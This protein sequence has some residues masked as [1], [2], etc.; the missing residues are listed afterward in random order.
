MLILTLASQIDAFHS[1]AGIG[2]KLGQAFNSIAMAISGLV[3]A[4]IYG[5]S[6]TLVLLSLIP[7]IFLAGVAFG[8]FFAKA[9]HASD[10]GLTGA[11]RSS[12]LGPC[13]LPLLTGIGSGTTCPIWVA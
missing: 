13:M 10:A 8:M 7:V 12:Q 1:Q 3:L 11:L 9:T 2:E 6:M 5:W 4:F